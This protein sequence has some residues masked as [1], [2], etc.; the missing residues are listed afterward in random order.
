MSRTPVAC[1]VFGHRWRF[2]ADG[3]TMRWACERDCG[4]HGEKAYDSP[5][6]AARYAQAFD[7]EDRSDIGRRPL[8]SLLPLRLARRRS[9][10]R[11]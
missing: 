11:S 1:R 3:A 7:R 5:E 9:S 6:Q 10:G 4:A 2:S 8:L